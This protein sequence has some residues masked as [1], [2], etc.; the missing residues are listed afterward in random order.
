M[1]VMGWGG[2]GSNPQTYMCIHTS[3]TSNRNT[4]KCPEM[5]WMGVRG[6]GGGKGNSGREMGLINDL[7]KHFRTL[8]TKHARARAH[9]HT[10]NNNNNTNKTKPNNSL[11]SMYSDRGP[12]V[13]QTNKGGGGGLVGMGNGEKKIHLTL[14]GVT[15][16]KPPTALSPQAATEDWT[17]SSQPFHTT[18]PGCWAAGPFQYGPS[19]RKK[20]GVEWSG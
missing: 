20:R 18:P 17:K 9:T 3:K 7:I 14:P 6:E 1:K 8:P 5:G 16:T 15:A 4:D 2:G 13:T 11:E 10:H 12:S 19:R